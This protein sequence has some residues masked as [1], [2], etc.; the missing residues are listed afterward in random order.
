MRRRRGK[1]TQTIFVIYAGRSRSQMQVNVE[2][3]LRRRILP[4]AFRAVAGATLPDP[5]LLRGLATAMFGPDWCI[6]EFPV[7]ARF[8]IHVDRIRRVGLVCYKL[9]SCKG[10]STLQRITRSTIYSETVREALGTPQRR[11]RKSYSI[12]TCS[13]IL[14]SMRSIERPLTRENIQTQDR[15]LPRE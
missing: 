10:L 7:C 5:F 15:C 2:S 1:Q 11:S 3:D 13:S 4:S 9:H 12:R 14:I 6:F 8:V